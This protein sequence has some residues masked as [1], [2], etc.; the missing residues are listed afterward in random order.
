ML[1][2]PALPSHYQAMRQVHAKLSDWS[3]SIFAGY[4]SI[5]FDKNLL[6]QA[7]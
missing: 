3:S 2:N 4:N 1:P 7:L 5:S 6:L